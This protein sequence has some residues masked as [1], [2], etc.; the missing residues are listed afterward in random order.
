VDYYSWAFLD[1]QLAASN[2]E[3]GTML[4]KEDISLR[5]RTREAPH[6]GW[7]QGR[8]DG[9]RVVFNSEGMSWNYGWQSNKH[10]SDQMHVVLALFCVQVYPGKVRVEALFVSPPF[11]VFSRARKREFEEAFAPELLPSTNMVDMFSSIYQTLHHTLVGNKNPTSAPVNSMCRNRILDR[12]YLLLL[13]PVLRSGRQRVPVESILGI[14]SK[15]V[16]SKMIRSLRKLAVACSSREVKLAHENYIDHMFQNKESTLE[17]I[18]GELYTDFDWLAHRE[19]E[20]FRWHKSQEKSVYAQFRQCR[21]LTI[22]KAATHSRTTVDM[23]ALVM[24]IASKRGLLPQDP[25]HPPTLEDAKFLSVQITGTATACIARYS[26][27]AE[28]F[29]SEASQRAY[30]KDLLLFKRA[31]SR[32][33]LIKK[34]QN[35]YAPAAIRRADCLDSMNGNW[36]DTCLELPHMPVFAGVVGK[37]FGSYFGTLIRTMHSKL[38]LHLSRDVL[39][40]Q[41]EILG[42]GGGVLVFVCDGQAHNFTPIFPLSSIIGFLKNHANRKYIAYDESGEIVVCINTDFNISA[43]LINKHS[44]L[45]GHCSET[46]VLHMVLRIAPVSVDTLSIHFTDFLIAPSFQRSFDI[47]FVKDLI[48]SESEFKSVEYSFSLYRNFAKDVDADVNTLESL[49]F[50]Q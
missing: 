16:D 20:D 23:F 1:T 3:V 27:G 2:Y 44:L 7:V 11:N 24:D 9:H 22:E 4:D 34:L 26:A 49:L 40:L 13:A 17:F 35:R 19:D 29:T 39:Q 6:L 48:V 21:R 45:R 36:L 28:V 42:F 47:G 43:Q 38:V 41:G 15:L 14:L 50:L 12:L 37:L 46:R 33:M 8:I 10:T 31:V 5:E 32:M 18:R 25:F 30:G